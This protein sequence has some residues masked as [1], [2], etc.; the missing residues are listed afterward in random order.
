MLR[1]TVGVGALTEAWLAL[2]DDLWSTRCFT[3]REKLSATGMFNGFCPRRPIS[4]DRP[5]RH[6]CGH[7]IGV[8]S[9]PGSSIAEPARRWLYVPVPPGHVPKHRSWCSSQRVRG[10]LRRHPAISAIRSY[11]VGIERCLCPQAGFPVR[12]IAV[13]SHGAYVVS[14]FDAKRVASRCRLSV[15]CYSLLNFLP[16]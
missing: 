15:Q 16:A 11:C 7:A 3:D 6:D 12:F 2:S 10:H 5:Q 14:G 8:R 9:C 13:R 1:L 4:L